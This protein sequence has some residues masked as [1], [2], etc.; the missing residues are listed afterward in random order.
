LGG[1]GFL[2][3]FF[4]FFFFF[5]FFF[6]LV[7]Y[8]SFTGVVWDGVFLVNGVWLL[9]TGYWLLLLLL[10]HC[11]ACVFCCDRLVNGMEQD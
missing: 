8:Y 3:F 1:W 10:M 7:V 2:C 11:V 4:W 9:A 5:F 6:C